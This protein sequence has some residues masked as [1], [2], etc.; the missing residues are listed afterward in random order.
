MEI[1]PWPRRAGGGCAILGAQPNP[2][3]GR[4]ERQTQTS[5]SHP[6]LTVLSSGVR[7]QGVLFKPAVLNWG[8]FCTLPG[9]LAMSE[10][11]FGCHN[12]GRR[13]SW[14]L[15]SKTQ[16]CC[17]TPRQGTGQGL[18]QRTI[19]PQMSAALR[20]WSTNFKSTL[21]ESPCLQEVWKS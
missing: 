12:W 4:Q 20:N 14:H 2:W 7:A 15:E 13:S 10:D 1:E 16:G 19:C 5:G 3:Q 6:V 18:L 21:A 9:G 11:I 17:P 8:P